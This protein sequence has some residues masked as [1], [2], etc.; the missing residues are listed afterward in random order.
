MREGRACRVRTPVGRDKRDPP[1]P[2]YLDQHS[3][4]RRDVTEMRV[5]QF[6]KSSVPSCLRVLR[7]NRP[8]AQGR[9]TASRAGAARVH[10]VPRVRAGYYMPSVWTGR[11]MPGVCADAMNC[12]P[13]GAEWHTMDGGMVVTTT[14]GGRIA[15]C[16]DRGGDKLTVV[17]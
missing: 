3:K 2:P 13:P 7:V 16:C 6:L 1:G 12:V 5:T 10:R 8:E 11:Y 9:P 17:G 15:T 14:D 4:I